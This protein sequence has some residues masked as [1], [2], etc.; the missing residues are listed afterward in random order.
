MKTES[1]IPSMRF[2]DKMM[3]LMSLLQKDI[4]MAEI[5]VFSGE[6]TRNFL[7]SGKI[8]HLFAIDPWIGGYD[9]GDY[10]SDC[11]NFNEVERL[12]IERISPYSKMVSILK[13]KG[14]EASKY[15]KDNSLDF[16]YIDANH[17]YEAVCQDINIWS[18][19]VKKGGFIS[20]HD[21]RPD[22]PGVVKAV[23][24]IFGSP[25]AVLP[26]SSW[27]KNL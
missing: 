8:L 16:V 14:D 21:Y 22:A 18:K 20:G 25:L 13:M 15:F 1:E 17:K 6:S 27:I 3:P 24:E 4:V 26:D 12:F 5:G 9:P 2:N 19:K 11:K 23:K 7:D 10:G